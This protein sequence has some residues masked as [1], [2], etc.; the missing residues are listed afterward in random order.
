MI[1]KI[2]L[3]YLAG[4]LDVPV[5]LEIPENPPD[6]FV[7]LEKTGGGCTNRIYSATLALQSYAATMYEAATLNEAVKAAMDALA[8]LDE[9]C[10][11]RPNSDYNYTDT[12][13]KRYRYQ[14]VYDVKHY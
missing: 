11:S 5:Y 2:V 12:A 1:E 13:S 3:D 9:V 10:A 4:T 7:L 6:S 8:E 14:A